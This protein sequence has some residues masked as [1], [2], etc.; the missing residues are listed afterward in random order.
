M[1]IVTTIG[2]D[3]GDRSSYLVK[4]DEDG[5]IVDRGKV[6]TNKKAL[7]KRLSGSE[8]CRVVIEAGTHSG[9]VS[10]TLIHLGFEVYVANPRQM[11]WL[12][13]NHRKTDK[14][15]AELLAQVGQFDPELLKP[16]VHRDLE[17]QEDLAVV[18]A[19]DKL[20]G[21]RSSL[22][23]HVRGTL[24]Q[25][26]IRVR[27]CSTGR[28]A[29]LA[30]EQIPPSLELALR[31]IVEMIVRLTVLI[32]AMDKTVLELCV[33]KY[34]ETELL[35]AIRG[36]GP[37]TALAFVLTM[38]SP[39]LFSKNRDAGPYLGLVR[40][41]DQSGKIDRE[42]G[43]TKAGNQ[44]MRRLLVNCAQYITGHFGEDSDLKRFGQKKAAGGGK[45]AKK[46]A[47]V[48]VARKLSVLMLHLWR[49]GEVYDPLYNANIA[50]AA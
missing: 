15:D 48:A 4:R 2:L 16:I 32:R 30:S 13:M 22:I 14:T 7:T 24:K 39:A 17:H 23:N 46:K 37:L 29:A 41:L 6:A 49:N 1:E 3:L 33:E 27:K 5:E 25:F 40:K 50:K 11:P 21:Q 8:G 26:G 44:L 10:R 35:L 45:G 38:G 19:R 34:P 20:V 31:P 12:Y 36:V 43:I 28:F 42:L 47:V 9:W 18:K